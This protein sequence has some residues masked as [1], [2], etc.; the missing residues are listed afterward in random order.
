[1]T[2]ITLKLL[3][4]MEVL[5][6]GE[7]VELPSS[8]KTRALLAYLA[9]S[10]RPQRRERLCEIFW[11][12]PD[13]PRGSLRWSLSKIRQIVNIDGHTRLGAD[14]NSVWMDRGGL[15][16]D[17]DELT[18]AAEQGFD[19]LS[20]PQVE[21]LA[22]SVRGAFL[23]DTSLPR[24]PAFEAWRTAEA[25]AVEALAA[26]LVWHLL[27][28]LAEEPVRALR[29]ASR[30]CAV[31]GDDPRLVAAIAS[32]ERAATGSRRATPPAPADPGRPAAVQAAA[33][34]PVDKPSIAVLPFDNMSGDPEQEY[35]SDGMTEDIITELARFRGLR[36]VAR[37]SSFTLKK[38]AV[39]ASEVGAM[40]GAEYMV[41]GS[42]RRVGTK[43]RITAQLID[44]RD[45]HHLWAE[46]YD[47]ELD[48]IFRV[49]EEIARTIVAAVEPALA[50]AER[51]R[52]Q[53]KPPESLGAWDWYQRGMSLMYQDTA[54]SN[55]RALA[56]FQR[57]MELD[58]DFA[59]AHAAAARVLANDL[60]NGFTAVSMAAIRRATILARRAIE[61]DDRDALAHM[62]LGLLHLL[63]C[64]HD[65]AIAELETAVDLNPSSAEAHHG[66]GFTL[67]FSGRPEDAVAEFDAAIRSSPYDIRA[68][69]FLEMRAWALLMC[70]RGEEALDSARASV[71]RPHAQHWSYATLCVVLARLGRYDEIPPFREEL[72]RRMPD[73]SARFVREHV[74]YYREPAHLDVYIRGLLDAGLPEE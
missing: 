16:I 56:H 57:A 45:D 37:N 42:V 49:Q 27:E 66:L 28:R 59:A 15:I 40:L 70:G 32:L 72:Q 50:G 64:H 8:R 65:Q 1:L 60:I 24:C 67:I 62:V 73:F 7:P 5:I 9:L 25:L 11:D 31:A 36:V 35:F 34:T 4:P 29:H 10:P 68:S 26:R 20:T 12:V 63:R 46:R 54:E 71:R 38:Q 19:A 13:D 18:R 14:R 47:R 33:Q 69:S 22:E 21:A 3:G 6:G 61:L 44:T 41:E 17:R 55:V 58:G 39:K 43:V 52:S 74:F 51:S 23:E 2:E 30:L 48:D 53:R